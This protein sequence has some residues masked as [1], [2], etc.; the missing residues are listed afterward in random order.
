MLVICKCH[1]IKKERNTL[2]K[3]IVNGKNNY[4]CSEQDY[5]KMQE[6]KEK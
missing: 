4:Y 5:I 6:E 1:G 3:V 2:Y